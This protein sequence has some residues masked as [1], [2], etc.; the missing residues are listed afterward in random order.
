MTDHHAIHPIDSPRDTLLA[1]RISGRVGREDMVGM[2]RLVGDAF[3]RHDKI[4]LLL[5]FDGFEGSDFGAGLSPEVLG[6]QASSLWNLRSYV[7][8]GA[9]DGARSMIETMGALI[10]VEAKTFD[11][12]AEAR[13]W[14]AAQPDLKDPA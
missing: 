12:E 1:F 7:V 11:T 14:L 2:A 3:D 5:V 9:P 4:D 6:V 13:A 10:P 8:A